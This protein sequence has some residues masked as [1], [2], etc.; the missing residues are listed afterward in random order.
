MTWGTILYFLIWAG[1]FAVM[2]RFGCGAHVMG[3]GGKHA[4]STSDNSQAP[5]D[6]SPWKAPDDAVDP[7]CGMTLKT[8]TAKSAVYDGQVYFFCSQACREKFE[9]APAN[10]FKPGAGWVPPGQQKEPHHGAHC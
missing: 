1:A 6:G 10:Y 9:A 8:T 3:H 7:V 2:M 4:G 5:H